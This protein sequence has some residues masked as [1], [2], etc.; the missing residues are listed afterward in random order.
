VDDIRE[1]FE[2]FD[3]AGMSSPSASAELGVQT[4][5]EKGLFGEDLEPDQVRSELEESILREAQANAAVQ[6]ALSE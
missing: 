6:S 2:V 4:L 3:L 5:R 1:V